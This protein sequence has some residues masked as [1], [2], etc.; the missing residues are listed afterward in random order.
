M[1]KLLFAVVLFVLTFTACRRDRNE[2]PWEG[3]E[4]SYYNERNEDETRDTHYDRDTA[5]LSDL[6]MIL[7]NK[8]F[9]AQTT[10]SHHY[11]DF[12]KFKTLDSGRKQFVLSLQGYYTFMC[13][14]LNSGD[15]SMVDNR[16]LNFIYQG[17]ARRFRSVSWE[18]AGNT[19]MYKNPVLCIKYDSRNTPELGIEFDYYVNGVFQHKEFNQV[20]EFGN[21]DDC[22][23]EQEIKEVLYIPFV[24]INWN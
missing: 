14:V 13:K 5:E 16:N 8:G 17:T 20:P 1:Q 21:N 23:S 9:Q 3:C 18:R 2:L 19:L 4:F 15:Y 7:Y 12:I 24:E 22:V 6:E 11:S 10:G